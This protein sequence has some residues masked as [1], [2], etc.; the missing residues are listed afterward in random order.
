MRRLDSCH[1]IIAAIL[2]APASAGASA[3]QHAASPDPPP[4]AAYT[5]ESVE[6]RAPGAVLRGRLLLPRGSGPH[7]AAVFIT[8]AGDG[9]EMPPLLEHLAENGIA[10]LSLYKRGVQ[11]STGNWRRQSFR[12]RA[13][14][15]IAGMDYLRTR[16]EVDTTRIGLVGHSQGSWIAQIVAAERGDVAYV[17]MLAAVAQTVRDQILTDERRHR[18][19]RGMPAAR[20]DREMRSLARSL[21]LA[22]AIQPAC[23]AARAHYICHIVDFDPAPYLERVRAPVLALYAELDPE[24]PP[25]ENIP[26]LEAGLERAPTRD[27]TVRT[28]AGANHLFWPARTGLRDEYHSLKREFVPGFLDTVTTWIRSR[29]VTGE[30]VA[31]PSPPRCSDCPDE[32]ERSAGHSAARHTVLPFPVLFYGTETRLGGGASVVHEVSYGSSGGHRRPTSSELSFMYTQNRQVIVAASVDRYTSANTYR[33]TGW[34]MYMDF[35]E[36]FHGIGSRLTGMQGEA[37]TSVNASAALTVRRKVAHGVY[38]GGGYGYSDFSVRDAVPGGQL[39]SGSISGSSGGSL[40]SASASVT[41]DTRVGH[42]APSGGMYG[43]ARIASAVREVGSDFTMHSYALDLR[44]YHHLGHGRIIAL[45]G[46]GVMARGD[47]PFQVLP[48]MGGA[49]LMRGYHPALY[50]D[51]TMVAAQ[52]ELRSP[53]VWRLGGVA[54]AGAGEVGRELPDLL[55]R[56][57]NLSY[58]AGARLAIRKQDG[59]NLRADYGIGSTGR[60]LYF[61]IGE[62]F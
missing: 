16:A 18:E 43:E 3:P 48:R 8:G 31:A 26:L 23:R 56:A 40:A 45:Q 55:R 59:F 44:R 47:V 61:G 15:V 42:Y 10:V 20:V 32:G 6:V 54:F 34:A 19:G 17:V 11:G 22:D 50:R 13:R 52:A 62:A 57:P 53:L 38:L 21:S 27:V 49:Q 36:M 28:F 35:P 46:Y 2:L 24:V 58:G 1:L 7:P 12:G 29:T 51:R 4:D 33:V 41:R 25:A 30:A 14:D 5:Q 9:G 39:A 37:F 60:Q